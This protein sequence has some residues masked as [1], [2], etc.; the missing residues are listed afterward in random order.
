M[1]DDCL[2]PVQA[3]PDEFWTANDFGVKGGIEAAFMSP[4]ARVKVWRKD[5]PVLMFIRHRPCNTTLHQPPDLPLFTPSLELHSS[6]AHTCHMCI[7]NDSIHGLMRTCESAGT[8]TDRTVAMQYAASGATGFIFEV[9]QGMI[10]RG[11]DVHWLS[12][13]PHEREILVH[14]HTLLSLYP[15]RPARRSPIAACR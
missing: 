7:G 9:Q 6:P 10:D 11:A 8:T 3:L 4:H 12:Q 14:T 1:P 5:G 2:Y 13:Y 15:H